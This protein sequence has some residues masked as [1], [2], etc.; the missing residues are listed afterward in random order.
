[1]VI[2]IPGFDKSGP[3]LYS[4]KR[5]MISHEEHLKADLTLQLKIKALATESLKTQ[6]CFTRVSITDKPFLVDN[7][8]LFTMI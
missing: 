6:F 2:T 8:V 7:F 5:K 4:D 3:N 1:M